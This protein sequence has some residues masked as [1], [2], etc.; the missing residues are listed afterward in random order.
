MAG[1]PWQIQPGPQAAQLA[2]T[3]GA[4]AK[5]VLPGARRRRRIDG[6]GRSSHP[7]SPAAF[8][9]E[10]VIFIDRSYCSVE[11]VAKCLVTGC[12]SLFDMGRLGGAPSGLGTPVRCGL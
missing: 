1:K 4:L 3:R 5:D 6:R 8:F 2:G 7:R 12:G 10:L 11:E 9:V